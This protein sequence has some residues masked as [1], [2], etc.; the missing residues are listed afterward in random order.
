LPVTPADVTVWTVGLSLLYFVAV[1]V[2]WIFR[3]KNNDVLSVTGNA[4]RF[5]SS[6]LILVGAI[7]PHPVLEA[8]GN[9]TPFL[10]YAGLAGLYQTARALFV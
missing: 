1:F 2:C 8:I 5:S 9:L 6:T 10:L 4:L 7:Y 3:R